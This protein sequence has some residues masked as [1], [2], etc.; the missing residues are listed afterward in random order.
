[1][2]DGPNRY[3][4][5]K[6][7][8]VNNVDPEGLKLRIK[9]ASKKKTL[10]LFRELTRL[11]RNIHIDEE[12]NITTR[13]EKNHL[14]Q[15]CVMT[16]SGDEGGSYLARVSYPVG[17]ELLKRLIDHKF[18]T[19]IKWD[20][21]NRPRAYA[22]VG[23][24]PLDQYRKESYLNDPRRKG[25]GKGSNMTVKWKFK[26]KRSEKTTYGLGEKHS[27]ISGGH[28]LIHALHGVNGDPSHLCKVQKNPGRP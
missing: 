4:Y 22:S 2:P 3:L 18:T 25:T 5:V 15:Y 7:N 8:P 10:K 20:Y 1:M 26:C 11:C 14:N 19:T 6:D 23:E 16:P 27:H 13:V 17:S 9:N 12:G 24:A 21:G 28:E